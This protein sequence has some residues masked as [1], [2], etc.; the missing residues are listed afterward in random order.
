MWGPAAWLGRRWGYVATPL[1]PADG[2]LASP[3]S[4]P[5]AS[6]S[7]APPPSS[8]YHL[9]QQLTDL[10]WPLASSLQSADGDLSW[11]LPHDVSTHLPTVD[12]NHVDHTLVD[13]PHVYHTHVDHTPDDQPHVDQHHVDH[14]LVDQPHI[15]QCGEDSPA[16]PLPPDSPGSRHTCGPIRGEHVVT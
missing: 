5:W 9:Q 16:H 13:Q 6:C 12:H 4:A 1:P 7:A 3:G 10:L 15:D 11:E 8:C 14:T 2:D